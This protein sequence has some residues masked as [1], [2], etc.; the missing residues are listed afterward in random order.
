MAFLGML[1]LQIGQ[2]GHLDGLEV[3]TFSVVVEESRDAIYSL[4][5]LFALFRFF[6]FF[7][8][9]FLISEIYGL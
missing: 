8:A 6:C 3:G 1:G 5:L 2:I 7:S 4:L 9:S